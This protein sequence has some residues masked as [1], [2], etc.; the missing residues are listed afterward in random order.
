[1]SL[2]K[3]FQNPAM[4]ASTLLGPTVG[5]GVSLLGTTAQIA[6]KDLDETIQ[7]YIDT[8]LPPAKPITKLMF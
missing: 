1:M 2:S 6:D 5:Q 8:L 4:T 3:P 7:K